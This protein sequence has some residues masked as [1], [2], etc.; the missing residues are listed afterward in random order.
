MPLHTSPAPY[1]P[2]LELLEDRRVP[3]TLA[4]L[5]NGAAPQRIVFF[6]SATPA[7]IFSQLTITNVLAGDT[8][9]SISFRP[10]TGGL[11]ALGVNSNTG[12]GRIYALNE[13]TAAATLLSPLTGFGLA[14]VLGP[15]AGGSFSI[16]F[17]PVADQ[18]RLIGSNG[19]NLRI[20]PALGTVTA[21]DTP[22]VGSGGTILIA[23]AAYDR[24]VSGTTATSLFGVDV[25]QNALD[26]IGSS[27]GTPISPNLGTVTRV[28]FFGNVFGSPSGFDVVPSTSPGGSAFA[29]FT[30]TVLPAGS[31]F[32]ATDSRLVQ[33]NL[34]TGAATQIGFIGNG[35]FPVSGLAV[36]PAQTSGNP[37]ATTANQ[38]FVEHVF[39]DLLGRPVEA[40]SL[41][42]LASLLDQ[43]VSRL[44]FVT[45]VQQSPEFLQRFVNEAF[46]LGM[47]PPPPADE[48][49]VFVT[50]LQNGGSDLA[51]LTVTGTTPQAFV[52]LFFLKDLHRAPS[53]AE[54][55]LHTL[56]IEESGSLRQ[57]EALIVSSDEYFN[58][59]P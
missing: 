54:V 23:A 28:G 35:T 48:L 44:Q 4:G 53:A 56:F 22:L 39:E 36:V 40:G 55:D 13:A 25:I 45:A 33:I 7:R 9:Q 14:T 42:L 12:T 27:N 52:N 6:D 3:T 31:L 47:K 21:V 38:R 32:P 30:D 58:R 24:K 5:E 59:N 1:R 46:Q 43:G 20:N 15:A 10:A 49:A 57:D 19:A 37:T 16:T 2:F 51:F 41:P 17:D 11:Y 8:I 26:L 34:A 18:I 29:V 50:Y